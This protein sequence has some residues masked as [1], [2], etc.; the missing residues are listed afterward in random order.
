MVPRGKLEV[1]AKRDG[2]IPDG[3]A[4]DENGNPSS[5]AARV[6]ANI[7]NKTGGGIF[8]IP[9]VQ[10]V[11]RMT[12]ENI[13]V[14]FTSRNEIPTKDAIHVLV[15]AVANMS[16]SK[17]PARQAIAASKFAGYSVQQIRDIVIPVLEGNIREIIS[18]TNFE[19]L[20]RGDKKAIPVLVE[21]IKERGFYDGATL[22]IAHCNG[23][24]PALM[25]R[26]AVLAEFPNTRFI[27]EPT[28]ALCSFY[29]EE[30]GL[31][32]GIEGGY[33]KN[34]NTTGF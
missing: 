10:R 12:L 27:L 34:N 1:Y 5:D 13:Q 6:L 29:A 3:W 15:D 28:G 14:D 9:M 31:M 32:I 8:V 17:D 24:A 30:G 33:N 25:L 19:S 7:I 4:L 18:Q 23:E 20:I 26:D 22:R 16:I 2:V 11:Q 21:M